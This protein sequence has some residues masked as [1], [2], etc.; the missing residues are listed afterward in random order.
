MVKGTQEREMG[1]PCYIDVL[2]E[3]F[4]ISVRY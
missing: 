2:I 4:A 1:K 3:F